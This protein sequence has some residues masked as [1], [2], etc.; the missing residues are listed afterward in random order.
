MSAGL[1]SLG[2]DH[3]YSCMRRANRLINRANLVQH[4]DTRSV[5]GGYEFR[6]VS[7]EK[8]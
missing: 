4:G 2:N 8:R 3:V 6:R 1:S 7:P 5:G